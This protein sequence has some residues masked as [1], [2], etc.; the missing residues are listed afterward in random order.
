MLQ[1]SHSCPAPSPCS[2]VLQLINASYGIR[3]L[4]AAAGY[5]HLI[6][7]M[8]EENVGTQLLGGSSSFAWA[9][10]VSPQPWDG[11]VSTAQGS[12]L[13]CSGAIDLG[14]L[15]LCSQVLFLQLFSTSH[16]DDSLLMC[17]WGS[18]LLFNLFFSRRRK[19]FPGLLGIWRCTSF[20]TKL[21]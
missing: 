14:D 5:Q 1:Q 9:A 18:L 16:A 20:W 19:L 12:L 6:Y 3:P 4:E 21:W 2:G 7:Q 15:Q 8:E 13:R 17:A 11:A 10:E